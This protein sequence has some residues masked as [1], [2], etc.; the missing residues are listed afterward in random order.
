MAQLSMGLLMLHGIERSQQIVENM[1]K[2]EP[3]EDTKD[4]CENNTDAQLN[5]ICLLPAFD[6]GDDRRAAMRTRPRMVADL[7]AAFVALD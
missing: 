5:Q 2:G 3:D 1:T 6:G 4:D 7:S